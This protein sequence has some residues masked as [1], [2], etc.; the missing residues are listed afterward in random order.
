MGA[1][2]PLESY[3]ARVGGLGGFDRVFALTCLAPG[4]LA[5]RPHSAEALLRAARAATTF[6]DP[7]IAAVTESGLAPGSAFVASEFVHGVSLQELA[8]HLES[9]T[10]PRALP[11]SVW[12][13]VIASIGA[14]IAAALAAAHAAPNPV[15]HGALGPANVMVTPQGAVKL[16]DF[17]LLSAIAT[18]LE[19]ALIPTRAA[20]MAPE[21]RP[22]GAASGGSNGQAGQPASI[23]KPADLF[24]LGAMLDRLAAIEAPEPPPGINAFP[25]KPMSLSLRPLLR[26]LMAPYSVQRPAALEAEASFRQ[27]LRECRGID[28]ALEVGTLV[29][30][31]MQLRPAPSPLPAGEA[32]EA[33]LG[34]QPQLT[35]GEPD[36]HGSF[37][38]PFADEPTAILDVAEDGKPSSLA[39]ILMEMRNTDG[40]AEAAETPTNIPQASFEALAQMNASLRTANVR[41]AENRAATIAAH[42]AIGEAH[43]ADHLQL[44]DSGTTRLSDVSMSM[45]PGKTPA[46]G[47]AVDAPPPSPDEAVMDDLLASDALSA[48][49]PDAARRAERR[50]VGLDR[51]A[52]TGTAAG[53]QRG[54]RR[55]IFRRPRRRAFAPRD[56]RRRT[57]QRAVRSD[58]R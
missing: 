13:A 11:P 6:K 56:D 57:H 40:E 19:I 30:L 50:D 41:E 29:R 39:A 44:P 45:F 12:G 25:V 31:I 51:G 17:G 8:E 24:A 33:M 58:Q 20:L 10:S 5:R 21:L 54:H 49:R 14:E 55:P 18:P 52:V 35:L 3:R 38:Q 23:D 47:I 36:D 26:S 53:A 46:G 34:A 2:G 48:G 16:L 37:D 43:V 7:R 42:A 28:V 1:D 27:I 22:T 32:A 9:S 4:A 15:I